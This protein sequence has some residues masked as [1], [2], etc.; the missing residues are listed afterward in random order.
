MKEELQE[1]VINKIREKTGKE[2]TKEE[3]S[4]LDARVIGIKLGIDRMSI[5]TGRDGSGVVVDLGSHRYERALVT[6]LLKKN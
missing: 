1:A 5:R 4:M 2:I 3:Y 6:S